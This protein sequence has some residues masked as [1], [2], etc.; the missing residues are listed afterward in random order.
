MAIQKL[1]RQYGEH[2]NDYSP[3]EMGDKINEIIDFLFEDEKVLHGV[4]PHTIIEVEST[5]EATIENV[6]KEVGFVA[7]SN[8]TADRVYF[9]KD[10][11]KQWVMNPETLLKLGFNFSDVVNIENEQMDSYKLGDDL[12]LKEPEPPVTTPGGTDIY[13][14]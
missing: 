7:R 9:I 3:V 2:K 1:L 10:D 12:D 8:S 4:E 13:N 6:Q 14:L 5:K 11:I